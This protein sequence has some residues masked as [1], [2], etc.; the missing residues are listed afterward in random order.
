MAHVS[1]FIPTRL[2]SIT[3]TPPQ[4]QARGG[5]Q[6]EPSRVRQQL[7]SSVSPAS[8]DA[9]PTVP[10]RRPLSQVLAFDCAGQDQPVGRR[11]PRCSYVGRSPA[12]YRREDHLLPA[13]SPDGCN[14]CTLLRSP[15]RS[16]AAWHS[17]R[18]VR[19]HPVPRPPCR[20]PHLSPVSLCFLAA[21][22][23]LCVRA[24]GIVTLGQPLCR[25]RPTCR[26]WLSCPV[27]A[28]AASPPP[29]LGGGLARSASIGNWRL[30]AEPSR[31]AASAV[32][33]VR[34]LAAGR[35]GER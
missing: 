27:L 12:T 5:F 34:R 13:S 1:Y 19:S 26:T 28:P 33:R 7:C 4:R 15:R 24:E 18:S 21:Q 35:S 16:A 20:S 29:L 17:R 22:C 8:L 6:P 10:P 30:P 14:A 32:S 31:R 2:T 3:M 11:R 25:P 23:P 9:G